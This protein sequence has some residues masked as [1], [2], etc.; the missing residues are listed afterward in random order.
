VELRSSRWHAAFLG[1]IAAL[2]LWPVLTT[3]L[4]GFPLFGDPLYPLVVL[5]APV[6]AYKFVPTRRVAWVEGD[7][8]HV[9]GKSAPLSDLTGVRMATIR[10]NLVP[11]ARHLIFAFR[12]RPTDGLMARSTGTRKLV[13][14][15]KAVSGGRRAAE[16]FT[17]Y[18]GQVARGVVQAPAPTQQPDPERPTAFDADAIIARHLAARADASFVG[19][20]PPRG[21]GR[22]GL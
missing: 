8:L 18:I 4:L 6:L 7:A 19:A 1:L 22:K 17:D 11:T 5:A 21:F 15:A 10:V 14:N 16:A 13:I 2:A 20:P 3:G 9:H 12:A